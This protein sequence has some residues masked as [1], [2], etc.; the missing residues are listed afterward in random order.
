LLNSNYR[1]IKFDKEGICNY[2]RAYENLQDKLTDFKKA[3]E[4][5]KDRFKR[6]K[7]KYA[8]DCLVGI[9]GGKDST[10][11]AYQLKNKYRLN[12]LAFTFDNGFLTDYARDNISQVVKKLDI[13]HIFYKVDWNI[14]KEFYRQATVCFGYPCPAC[15]YSSYAYMNK[16][17]FEKQIPFCVHG[18]SRAQ[19][20]K[21]LVDNSLDPFLPFIKNN[22][23]EYSLSKVKATAEAVLKKMDYLLKR[24][25]KDDELR[26]EFYNDFYPDINEYRQAELPPEFLGYFLYEKYDENKIK[27]TIIEKVGWKKPKNDNILTHND[28]SIHDAAMYLYRHVFGYSLLRLELSVM[29]REGDISRKEALNRLN[30]EEFEKK[31]EES[32][33]ILCQRCDLKKY[34]INQIITKS[35]ISHKIMKKALEIKNFFKKAPKISKDL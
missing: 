35:K 22:L 20:F 24:I 16:I 33:D 18:R 5:L 17:A 19:M 6:F 27:Q 34:R 26:K 28:C 8:Y 2:C 1:N 4:L 29:I 3:Q 30:R 12:I 25:I 7:G 14:H 23:S 31:P 9:T 11:L 10:Y 15:A 32:M 21:E 13:D